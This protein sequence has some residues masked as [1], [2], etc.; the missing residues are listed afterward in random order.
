[1]TEVFPCELNVKEDKFKPGRTWTGRRL[2]C[3]FGSAGPLTWNLTWKGPGHKY[4][5]PSTWRVSVSVPGRPRISPHPSESRL[6]RATWSQLNFC[7]DLSSSTSNAFLLNHRRSPPFLSSTTSTCTSSGMTPVNSLV[8]PLLRP[9]SCCSSAPSAQKSSPARA[10]C[11]DTCR[12]THS[13]RGTS[14]MSAVSSSAAA[15]FSPAT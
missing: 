13:L 9:P 7:P 10:P 15:T 2:P 6:P 5:Y 14:A 1:M 12:T 8:L 11:L 4:R 3:C